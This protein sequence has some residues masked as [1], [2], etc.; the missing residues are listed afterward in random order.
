MQRHFSRRQLLRDSAALALGL[1]GLRTLASRLSVEGLVPQEGP[2]GYGPLI[3]D[4]RG[5]LNLPRGFSYSVFSKTGERMDDGLYVPACHDGMAAFPG[6]DGLTILVRNHEAPAAL[7]RYGP[8]GWSNELFA[9]FDRRRMYDAGYGRTPCAGGTTTLVYDT[10]SQSLKRHFLSLA[11]TAVNC[12]GGPTPWGTWITCEETEQQADG[13]YEKNHGYNFEVPASTE[14]GLAE[15]IP[16]VAMGRFKHEAVAVHPPTGIIYQTEDQHEGLIYR[17]IPTVPGQLRQGGRLQALAVLGRP[18]L[19]TRNWPSD[20]ELPA[21]PVMFP[22]E[23]HAVRWIDLEEIDSP[24]NDLRLRGRAAGAACFARGEGMWLGR[25][26]VYFACTNGGPK[27]LGQIWKYTPSPTEGT[28]EENDRPGRLE[29]FIESDGESLLENCDNL[30]V[31]PWGDLVIAEDSPGTDRL[32]G[33]TPEGVCYEV[34]KCVLND[35]EMAGP[36]FSP[37]G[38]TLFVNIQWPGLTLAITGP[39]GKRTT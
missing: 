22:G 8:F 4:P 3:A 17:F 36:C 38:S 23:S 27:M 13:T 31:A 14:I 39:W 2:P 35:S 25:D 26:G 21:A 10:R 7:P 37:D 5:V 24:R 16:L 15:P 18:G 12:A 33:I 6:P 19:D 34:A 29:L 11:G 28:L 9:S 1:S 20:D 32:L 30:T